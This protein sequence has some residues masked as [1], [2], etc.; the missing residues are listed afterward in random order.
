MKTVLNLNLLAIVA[1]LCFTSFYLPIDKTKML[2]RRW[3]LVDFVAPQIEQNFKARGI[4]SERRTL[5]MKELVA[6]SFIDF[7]ADG[8]YEVSILGSEPETQFWTFKESDS[9]DV[10]FVHKTRESLPNPVEVATLSKQEL[11]ILLN[12]KDGEITRLHF[13]PDAKAKKQEDE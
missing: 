4:T 8:T 9:A 11:V 3:S 10:L 2:L 6:D 1:L 7:R 5:L 12:D 13:V